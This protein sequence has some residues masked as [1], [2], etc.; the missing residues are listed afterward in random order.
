[1]YGIATSNSTNLSDYENRTLWVEVIKGSHHGHSSHYTLK[2]SYNRLGQTLQRIQR[3][4]GKV[5]RVVAMSELELCHTDSIPV[6]CTEVATEPAEDSTPVT[7]SQT[8]Q[9][10][11]NQE[12]EKSHRGYKPSGDNGKST[13]SNRR[14]KKSKHRR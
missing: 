8:V 5:V 14:E 7:V 1:M 6:N 10:K 13:K 12:P 9:E 3:Q 2:V 11:L 4:G